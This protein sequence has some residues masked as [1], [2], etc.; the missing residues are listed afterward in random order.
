MFAPSDHSHMQAVWGSAETTDGEVRFDGD[1]VRIS[2]SPT[3]TVRGWRARW[4]HGDDG[5]RASVLF[6][7]LGIPVL[8]GAVA[9]LL[10]VT[11][12]PSEPPVVTLISPGITVLLGLAQWYRRY[13]HDLVVPLEAVEALS[14][15]ENERE[16]AVTYEPRGR[17]WPDWFPDTRET[18]V[19]LRT[20]ADCRAAKRLVDRF[21][22]TTPD[23][24]GPE[25]TASG[26]DRRRGLASDGA[27]DVAFE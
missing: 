8:L 14:L 16:L 13:G 15:D 17:F 19:T 11:H 27:E 4:R 22:R 21:E 10:W 2:R 18:S 12:D 5:E 26:G 6:K 20:P 23:D 9:V 25:A 24:P 7:A 3:A 1:E